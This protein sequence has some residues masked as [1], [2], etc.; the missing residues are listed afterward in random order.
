MEDLTLNS[1]HTTLVFQTEDKG[2]A[3]PPLS[4]FMN[5]V[6]NSYQLF[7]LIFKLHIIYIYI[8]I[9]ILYYIYI[10]THTYIYRYI[11][12]YAQKKRKGGLAGEGECNFAHLRGKK[13]ILESSN[14]ELFLVQ[15]LTINLITKF[16]R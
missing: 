2:V 7:Q 9:Y 16:K 12:I 1:L 11:Y 8:Y 13:L 15:Y 5:E 10:Y 3:C 6:E 14:N 4:L